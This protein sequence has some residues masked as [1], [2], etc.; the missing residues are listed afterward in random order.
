MVEF[1]LI[2]ADIQEVIGSAIVIKILSRG[3]FPYGSLTEW[4]RLR[5]KCFSVLHRMKEYASI[6]KCSVFL[7]LQNIGVMKSEASLFA[8]LIATMAISFAWLFGK[9]KSN[10]VELLRGEE[11]LFPKNLTFFGFFVI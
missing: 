5:L 1:A 4:L 2:G 11:M 9:T 7:F 3:F 10:V 8:V 6:R